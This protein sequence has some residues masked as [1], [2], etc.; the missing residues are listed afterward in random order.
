MPAGCQVGGSGIAEGS[1]RSVSTRA[2]GSASPGLAAAVRR[3]PPARSAAPAGRRRSPAV[4]SG[5][6]SRRS[7]PTG[8]ADRR[9]GRDASVPARAAGGRYRDLQRVAARAPAPVPDPPA[10]STARAAAGPRR[11]ARAIPGS[12]S[13]QPTRRSRR[14][15]PAAPTGCTCP[16]ATGRAERSRPCSCSTATAAAP[17]TWTTSPVCPSW[18]TAAASWPSTRRASRSAPA[19]RSGRGRPGRGRGR[20]PALHHRPARRPPRQPL[21]RPG[22]GG[23]R[24]LSAGGGITALVAC[25]LA[26]RVASVAIISGALYTEPGECRPEPSPASRSPACSGASLPPRSG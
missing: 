7:S 2:S 6:G 5:A 15:R 12:W 4:G 17:P 25:D 13:C 16:P 1:A 24:R 19:G 14:V 18:P 11:Y 8:S 20:R 22:P 10:G 21:R 3:P 26:G 9:V 23:R